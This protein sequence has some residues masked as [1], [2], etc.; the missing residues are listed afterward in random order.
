MKKRFLIYIMI[1][2]VFGMFDFY[3]HRF[4]SNALGQGGTIWK[5]FTY[6]IWLVPLI[7][8]TLFEI[9]ISQS[10]LRTALAGSFTWIFSII[11]YYL[12]MAI[13]FAFIGIETRPELHITG[14]GEDPY[15]W[16]NWRS[17]FWE[18]IVGNIIEWSGVA[19]GGGFILGLLMSMIYH[20]LLKLTIK[21]GE[22]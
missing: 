13:Q 17:V 11:S 10:K 6:G 18:D 14:L 22:I 19:I 12:F 15:F 7:P 16:G 5:M 8:I 20:Y 21:N 2:I 3:F 1:G 9:R 4:I